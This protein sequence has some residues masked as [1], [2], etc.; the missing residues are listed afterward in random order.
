[1]AEIC[2]CAWEALI[3]PIGIITGHVHQECNDLLGN[4]RAPTPMA[5]TALLVG[6]TGR[7]G[8]GPLQGREHLAHFIGL[9]ARQDSLPQEGQADR[10]EG[11]IQCSLS[12]HTQ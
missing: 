2:E 3:A 9:Q 8:H 5:I 6:Q 4:R 11:Q 12:S 7:T 10:Q 1:M